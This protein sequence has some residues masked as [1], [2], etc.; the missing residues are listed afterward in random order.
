[1]AIH[2]NDLPYD[3]LFIIFTLCWDRDLRRGRPPFPVTASHVCRQW[4]EHTLSTPSFW[5]DL[6]FHESKLNLQKHQ[7]WIERS[8]DAPIDI[9]I[10]GGLFR[11]SSVKTIKE[12]MR[13]IVP[14]CDRWRSLRLV[15]I[16]EKIIRIIFDRLLHTPMHALTK[17]EVS[18]DYAIYLKHTPAETRWRFRPFFYGGA[19]N[20]HQVTIERLPYNHID[21]RFNSLRVLEIQHAEFGNEAVSVIVRNVQGILSRLPNIQ[22]LRIASNR[23]SPRNMDTVYVH[24][25]GLDKPF[26]LIHHHLQELSL[27]APSGIKNAI[28]TAF[29][30]PKVLCFLDRTR[31][32]PQQWEITIGIGCLSALG[33]N[34]PFQS[35][36]SL[37]LGGGAG[38]RVHYRPR[39]PTDRSSTHLKHLPK[40]L[41]GLPMLESLTLDGVDLENER[42]LGS[43][44]GVCPRLRW[45]TLLFCPGYTVVGLRSVVEQ[46]SK[47]LGCDILERLVIYGMPRSWRERPE[48]EAMIW[49]R[50]KL[51][52]LFN[53]EA[54][55]GEPGDDY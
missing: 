42:Y 46:R 38:G 9:G 12:V 24:P 49:L 40:A 28:I 18:G 52:L 22:I 34:K 41:E 6:R 25:L 31:G 51:D 55:G 43:L 8:A 16:P 53:P 7:T 14:Y 21:S 44:S 11:H 3:I 5:A 30:L 2:I 26:T 33:S 45:L 35:L 48:M 29:C 17:L 39:P 10:Y 20:L 23:Y 4:R 19:P 13:L 37:R 1:M 15:S 36:L 50:D 47:V 27:Q 32:R 54:G